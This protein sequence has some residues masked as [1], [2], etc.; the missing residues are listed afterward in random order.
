M[1]A[2]RRRLEALTLNAS[3][4]SGQLLSDGWFLRLAPGEAKRARSVNAIH[5]STPP[6][7]EKIGNCES[8]YA[9]RL[10]EAFGFVERYRYGYPAKAA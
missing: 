3:A 1:S 6:I 9:F 10:Y 5:G 7:A 8:V 2:D 4:A